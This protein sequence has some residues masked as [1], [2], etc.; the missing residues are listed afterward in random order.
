MGGMSEQKTEAEFRSIATD[1]DAFTYDILDHP[2]EP[3]LE[4]LIS[5]LKEAVCLAWGHVWI[6]D[7]CGYWQHAYCETCG[8][9]KH[10][11]LVICCAD[12]TSAMGKTT[13]S[14]YLEGKPSQ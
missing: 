14:E 11:G 8:E 5:R 7:H 4:E 10:Q 12:L 13:E 9:A 6:L 2:K 1:L 3:V